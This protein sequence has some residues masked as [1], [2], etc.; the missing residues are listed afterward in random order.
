MYPH[1][2]GYPSY[3]HS[4]NVQILPIQK[5]STSYD[6]EALSPTSE[7]PAFVLPHH[8]TMSLHDPSSEVILPFDLV[9]LSSYHID[10]SA[11]STGQ[12]GIVDA[13]MHHTTML[14]EL[15]QQLSDMQQDKHEV[16]PYDKGL[17][18]KLVPIVT[19]ATCYDDP[20]LNETIILLFYESNY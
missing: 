17:P 15:Q 12:S 1:Y 8:H 4:K 14:G 2:P 16:Y 18:S 13:E 5:N 6:P 3:S 10:S 7:T 9:S 19:G 20:G 11:L